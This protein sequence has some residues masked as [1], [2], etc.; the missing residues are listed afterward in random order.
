VGE[1]RSFLV[2]ATPATLDQPAL[3]ELI[4]RLQLHIIVVHDGIAQTY[5]PPRAGEAAQS[6]VQISSDERQKMPLFSDA[7]ST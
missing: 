6:Q 5:F 7:P 1:A 3:H 4:D 2:N